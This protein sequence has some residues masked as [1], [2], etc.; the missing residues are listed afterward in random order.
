MILGAG[1]RRTRLKLLGNYTVKLASALIRDQSIQ[2][3]EQ[4]ETARQEDF[5]LRR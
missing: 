1:G 4:D 2:K 3:G 5:D